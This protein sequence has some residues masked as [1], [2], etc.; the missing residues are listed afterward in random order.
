MSLRPT[1]H[2]TGPGWVGCASVNPLTV[3]CTP[4]PRQIWVGVVKRGPSGEEL[5]SSYA[6]RSNRKYVDDLGNAIG[7]YRLADSCPRMSARPLTT[8]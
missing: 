3:L 7:E 8:T 1:R 4:L 6:N 2:E 5:N